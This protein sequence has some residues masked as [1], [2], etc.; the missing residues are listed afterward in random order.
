MILGISLCR[1]AMHEMTA[2]I[3]DGVRGLVVR[4]LRCIYCTKVLSLLRSHYPAGSVSTGSGAHFI[5]LDSGSGV[6]QK[7]GS[8]RRQLRILG[9]A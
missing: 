6:S 9:V 2:N 4:W 1:I 7:F 5:N 8:K 3:P